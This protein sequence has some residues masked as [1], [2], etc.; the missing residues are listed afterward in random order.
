MHRF[1]V[2]RDLNIIHLR[3]IRLIIDI[4]RTRKKIEL[5]I[6]WNDQTLF[7][8]FWRTLNELFVDIQEHKSA[9][10]IIPTASLSLSSPIKDL[11]RE[12]E[13][14]NKNQMSDPGECCIQ[15]SLRED[16]LRLCEM[17]DIFLG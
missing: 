12:F 8:L 10:M 4:R 16:Y 14:S 2:R 17:S 3:L 15:M 5:S 7:R 1:I 13:G 11:P 6:R 9:C